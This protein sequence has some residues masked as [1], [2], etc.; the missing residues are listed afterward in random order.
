[1]LVKAL[2]KIIISGTILEQGEPYEGNAG[3]L[4][5]YISGG[6]VEE[7]ESADRELGDAEI[8]EDAEEVEKTTKEPESAES[9]E[10][11]EEPEKAAKKQV[12]RTYRRK[13]GA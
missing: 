7:V 1:M 8:N 2:K 6:Y 3:E 5:D 10:D 4:E 11:E 13:T 12:K 9:T